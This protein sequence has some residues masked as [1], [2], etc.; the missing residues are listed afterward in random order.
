[1]SAMGPTTVSARRR[2]VFVTA[3]LTQYRGPLHEQVR[4]LL[5]A[6][7]IDWVV[8]YSAPYGAAA[9]K[10]DTIRPPWAVEVPAWHIDIGG[11][12]ASWQ[13]IGRH[14]RGADLIVLEQQ[15]RALHNYPLLAARYFG[16][17]TKLAFF[18]HGRNFQ[19]TRE[20]LGERIKRLLAV[21]VDWWF[22]YTEASAL[23]LTDA[24][25]PAERITVMNNAI[26]TRGLQADLEL[27]TPDDV[28]ALRLEHGIA[29]NAPLGLFIGG[30]YPEKRLPFLLAAAEIIRARRPD[31]V[32]LIAG[33]GPDRTVLKHA[34]H[35]RLLGSRFG[36]DKAVLLKAADLLLMPGLVG[37]VVL[38]A[39]CA[40]LPIVTTAI[41]YHSPEFAYLTDGAQGLV[42][43]DAGSVHAYAETVEALLGDPV[44]LGDMTR[45]A[46]AAASRFGIEAMAERLAVGVVAAL[47][48]AR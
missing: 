6:Q 26:D 3:I 33:D 18:G 42:V 34:P 48:A 17:R 37:L 10:G 7:G 25:M 30:L 45:S 32:L 4:R 35:L 41:D 40:G 1:M 22:A 9:T 36:R 20:T 44:H 23:A 47:E 14:A 29:P 2:V 12:F 19:E 8:L 28:A 13:R 11:K 38:D 43:Q 16:S 39:F 21:Q 24:G 15:N 5:D 31:F 27:V 46:R